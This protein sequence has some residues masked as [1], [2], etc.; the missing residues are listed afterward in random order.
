M[1]QNEI[2]DNKSE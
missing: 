1:D 2:E